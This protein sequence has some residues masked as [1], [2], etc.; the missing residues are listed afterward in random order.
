MWVATPTHINYRK[1]QD[2]HTHTTTHQWGELQILGHIHLRKLIMDNKHYSNSKE[3]TAVVILSPH[4]QESQSLTTTPEVLHCSIESVLTYGILSWYC[5]SSAANRKSLQ[6][7]IKTTQ[8]ITNLHHQTSP[9]IF[10]SRCLLKTHNI[11]KDSFHPANYLFEL[12]P[13]GTLQVHRNTHHKIQEQFLSQRS[14][15]NTQLWPENKPNGPTAL[16][17]DI[18]TECNALYIFCTTVLMHTMALSWWYDD[19][20]VLSE[21]DDENVFIDYLL[22]YLSFI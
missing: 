17:M 21:W 16:I 9:N 5:S 7:T 19:M 8:N 11:L 2:T 12:L 1:K 18:H 14:P 3:S 4:T 15:L 6:R 13:S 10:N 22:C 20:N